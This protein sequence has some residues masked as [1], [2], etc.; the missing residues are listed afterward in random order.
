MV[1]IVVSDGTGTGRIAVGLAIWVL[2]VLVSWNLHMVGATGAPAFIYAALVLGL[3]CC[4]LPWL[5]ATV[6]GRRAPLLRAWHDPAVRLDPASFG[7]I[8][9]AALALAAFM[10]GVERLENRIGIA[11]ALDWLEPLRGS[12][13]VDMP[14]L[15]GFGALVLAYIFFFIAEELLYRGYLQ[16]YVFA[17]L[18]P[19]W[20]I[21]LTAL[22]FA[23]GHAGKGSLT[24]N[25]V[26]GVVLGTAVE[27]TG[28]VWVGVLL[29]A[30]LNLVVLALTEMRQTQQLH[31][32]WVWL[33]VPIL[34]G[35]L[36]YL[37]HHLRRRATAR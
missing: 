35:A 25:L 17:N 30:T 12:L 27:I 32:R 37:H 8:A 5:H 6:A 20:A 11:R 1:R 15:T 36:V 33:A 16:R 34:V 24:A 28:R 14:M 2:F 18:R 31:T 13:T 22:L 4:L 21:L 29:H 23:L 26:L 19:P 7:A 3:I 10:S 9:L